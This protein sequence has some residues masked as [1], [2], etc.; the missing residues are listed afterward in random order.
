MSLPS[1]R[2]GL[3]VHPTSL[4]SGVIDADAYRLIDFLSEAGLRVWQVLPLTVPHADGSPYAALSAHAG[5]PALLPKP[6]P[7]ELAT[8]RLRSFSVARP[9]LDDFA[10][11]MAAKYTHGGAPWWA[12]PQAL[13]D[14]HPQT[15][16]RLRAHPAYRR[17]QVEQCVWFETWAGLRRYAA[18][19]GVTLMGDMPIFVSDDSCEVWAR[20]DLFK[21]DAAGRP[22]VVTGVPP[23]YFSKNGQRWGNPHYQWDVMARDGFQFWVDRAHT[24]LGLV[25]LVRIDHFRGF[26]AAYEI[27][28][29]RDDGMVGRWVAAPGA[30]LF[31]QLRAALGDH[32][33][34]AEDLGLITDEVL[35]LRDQFGLP[36]MR[37]L[38]FA[39]DGNPENPHLPHHH[40]ENCIAYTGTHDNDT[41]LGWWQ[42]ITADERLRVD[43][44]LGQPRDPMPWPLMRAALGSPA[45]L[46]VL[47][48]QDVLELGSS[49]RM[50]TPSTRDGNWRWRFKWEQL[51]TG[52]AARLCHD[53]GQSGRA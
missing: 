49:G 3:L 44:Y 1:R 14:R 24:L 46:A 40:V 23:D 31:A 33:F 48:I 30:Q 17:T 8:K 5:N 4:P 7:S 29:D 34:V 13:R 18:Q 21:L 19:R 25:D 28:A 9:W 39:F 52:L 20:R 22:Q 45:R 10:L 47:T 36:G 2:A 50:N 27:P 51:P 53:I 35:A 11:F 37:V 16:A 38:Q 6:L 32:H 42:A 41:V 43:A 12:W 15:L 26:A